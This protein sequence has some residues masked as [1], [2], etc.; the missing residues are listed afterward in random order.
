M[1]GLC[2]VPSTFAITRIC[3]A[4]T[5][6]PR[7]DAHSMSV[8]VLRVAACAR[9]RR[10]LVWMDAAPWLAAPS[11]QHVSTQHTTTCG[12]GTHLSDTP[13]QPFGRVADASTATTRTSTTTRGTSM[14]GTYATCQHTRTQTKVDEIETQK[15]GMRARATQPAE[16]S[17]RKLTDSTRLAVRCC[18]EAACEHTPLPNTV[19]KHPRRAI[20]A[21]GL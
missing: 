15:T 18:V 3:P 6:R 9:V 11:P 1:V 21:N 19:T 2:R 16:R 17:T 10:T 7:T 13:T 5:H 14:K 4:C 12:G 8:C 20:L